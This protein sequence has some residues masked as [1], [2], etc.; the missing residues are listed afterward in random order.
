MS[1]SRK[2]KAFM[3]NLLKFIV[4]IEAA[5]LNPRIKNISSLIKNNTFVFLSKL[6]ELCGFAT[7]QIF[8]ITGVVDANDS[9]SLY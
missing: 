2:L 4:L 6:E 3:K 7:F 1:T 8:F 5:R 9:C